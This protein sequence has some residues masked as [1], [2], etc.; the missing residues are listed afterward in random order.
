MDSKEKERMGEQEALAKEEK[1][2]AEYKEYCEKTRERL[3]MLERGGR[4][5]SVGDD[6][7]HNYLTEDGRQEEIALAKKDL[8]KHCQ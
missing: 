5:Y 4:L 2:E 7:E 1:R 6:G 8:E 3:S